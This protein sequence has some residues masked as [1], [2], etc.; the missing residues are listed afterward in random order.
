MPG[1]P[2]HKFR[3]LSPRARRFFAERRRDREL[4]AAHALGLPPTHF[5][6]GRL[7][8]DPT[9]VKP[10]RITRFRSDLKNAFDKN[11]LRALQTL[12]RRIEATAIVQPA[13]TGA[14]QTGHLRFNGSLAKSTLRYS[15]KA[16]GR[17]KVGTFHYG[18]IERAF[19]LKVSVP[20]QGFRPPLGQR[21]IRME[22]PEG[23]VRRSAT[24]TKFGGR[25]LEFRGFFDIAM[26]TWIGGKI[27]GSS[28]VTSAGSL[29][30]SDHPLQVFT[31]R[32][33]ISLISATGAALNNGRNDSYSVVFS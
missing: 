24:Y 13:A 22:K 19:G 15:L 32:T 4:T 25:T 6:S 30:R 10:V 21:F 9:L 28:S 18:P 3:R 14:T 17:S 31:R 7:S 33:S 27:G 2:K 12:T 20:P 29:R 5:G 1:P 26:K 11:A 8:R 23:T 16:T